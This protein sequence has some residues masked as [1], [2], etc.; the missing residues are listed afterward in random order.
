MA[1]QEKLKDEISYKSTWTQLAWFASGCTMVIISLAKSMKILSTSPSH[2]RTWIEFNLSVLLSYVLVDLVS[3]I[4]HWA[5]DNYGSAQTPIFGP[6]IEH[7]RAHHSQPSAITKYDM[8]AILHTT[9]R[10]F[11]IA[12]LPINILSNDPVLL[13]FV[14]VFAGF[15]IFSMKLHAWSHTPKRQLPRLVAV[16]QDI[17]VILRWSQHKLHHQPP[18]KG[19]YCIVSGICNWMLD[20]FKVFEAMEAIIFH[21]V[22]VRPRS[23]SEPNS[24]W[25]PV[26]SESELALD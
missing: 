8:A 9:S 4:Y 14:G 13:G 6:Q 15:G 23:W 24:D 10:V 1:H 16:L 3:G 21:V 17:G 20:E 26:E 2:P 7:F 22:G 11:M 18:F 5:V 19:N 12:I 25:K